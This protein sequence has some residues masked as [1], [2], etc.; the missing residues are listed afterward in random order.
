MTGPTL[1]REEREASGGALNMVSTPDISFPARVD[2]SEPLA[3]ARCTD[4]SG[5]D[6]KDL[7]P[8]AGFE[9]ATLQ[10]TG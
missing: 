5:I 3:V 4:V 8:Q 1:I 10:L 7:A 6:R 9:P 2:L